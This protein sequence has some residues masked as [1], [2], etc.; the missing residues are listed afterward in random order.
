M[1]YEYIKPEQ[2]DGLFKDRS[3]VKWG[4]IRKVDISAVGE[5]RKKNHLE[6]S[7]VL[8]DGEESLPVE[9]MKRKLGL[10]DKVIGYLP[11]KTEGDETVYLRIMGRSV[12]KILFLIIL[13]TALLGTALFLVFRAARPADD[14]P[15]KIASGE[16]YNPNPENIR[17]PG[18]TEVY[19]DA[20][21]TRV[22][23]LLLNVEGNAYNLTYTI[24]LQETEEVIYESKAIPPGYG[25]REFDMY[26]T[27]ESGSYPITIHVA[28]SAIDDDTGESSAAFNAGELDAMLVV[29]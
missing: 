2:L 12:V 13:L 29:R 23:Q 25:V 16:M 1:R 11:C 6:T 10:F 15:I 24:M 26:R 21:S 9:P 5:V 7:D 17:L 4:Y 20:G 19:A 28:S 22:N 3:G 18:I 8:Y 27:F 14:T